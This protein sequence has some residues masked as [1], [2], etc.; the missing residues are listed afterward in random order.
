MHIPYSFALLGNLHH[1]F[2]LVNRISSYIIPS[3]D[4]LCAFETAHS[5]SCHKTNKCCVLRAKRLGFSA[6]KFCQCFTTVFCT[7]Y[8][9]INYVNKHTHTKGVY[10]LKTNTFFGGF[11]ASI[12]SIGPMFG[13]EKT[14]TLTSKTRGRVVNGQFWRTIMMS[15]IM[16]WDWLFWC[17]R[18]GMPRRTL[19]S[20]VCVLCDVD[21]NFTGF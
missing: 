11:N 19:S 21:G 6:H 18:L 5:T 4:D 16:W 12:K 17:R 13:W 9:I 8:Y 14:L 15:M 3:Q 10:I 20:F 7:M 2:F 1:F